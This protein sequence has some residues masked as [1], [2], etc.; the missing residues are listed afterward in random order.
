MAAQKFIHQYDLSQYYLEEIAGHIMKNTGG[1]TL[2]LG[3]GGNVDPF[4]SGGSYTT[5]GLEQ[6]NPSGGVAVD[7]FTG[8]GAYTSGSGGG[9]IPVLGVNPPPDPWMQGAYTTSQANGMDVDTPNPYFPHT[10]FI[11]FDQAL[12]AEPL[13]NKLKEFNSKVESE[14]KLE[15]SVIEVLPNLALSENKDPDGVAN[16]LRVLRWKDEYIFPALDLVRLVL[17]HPHNQSFV[18]DKSFLDQLFSVCLRNVNKES[19]QPTQML[20]LRV[21]SNLFSVAQGEEFLMLYRESV[22]TRIFEHLF[23]IAAENKNI[24]IAATT[25]ML[26]YTVALSKRPLD[27]EGQIQALSVLGV[28]FLTFLTGRIYIFFP[29]NF[30]VTKMRNFPQILSLWRLALA[31]FLGIS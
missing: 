25:V 30:S 29:F 18:L 22:V 24:Q 20:A 10:E 26:N 14:L 13:I 27:E 16:L 1:K 4:T 2:G 21:L 8:S 11:R 12:K 5:Q 7:P 15:D 17:L 23:P 3:A 19:P 6:F 9:D 31:N 28:N